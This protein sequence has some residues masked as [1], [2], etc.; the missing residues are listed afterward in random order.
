MNKITTINGVL[1]TPQ[2]DFT[3]HA[4]N[5]T[6]HTTEEERAAW[7]AKAETSELSS[8]VDMDTFN[9]HQ[10][11]NSSHI[12]AKEREHW[13]SSVSTDDSGNMELPGNLTAGK[14]TFTGSVTANQGINL[15]EIP[16]A[17]N[18]AISKK[19]ADTGNICSDV[20]S[21]RY[22][23]CTKYGS[24][25]GSNAK[26]FAPPPELMYVSRGKNGRDEADY[27]DVAFFQFQNFS[28][29]AW[30]V[31][32]NSTYWHS[33]NSISLVVGPTDDI[34]YHSKLWRTSAPLS[35]DGLFPGPLRTDYQ[36]PIP[37]YYW[38]AAVTIVPCQFSVGMSSYS[39]TGFH[40]GNHVLPGFSWNNNGGNQDYLWLILREGY[41]ELWHS[42]NDRTSTSPETIR[43]T[44]V[45]HTPVPESSGVIGI[46]SQGAHR[47][48][49]DCSGYVQ[50]FQAFESIPGWVPEWSTPV[51]DFSVTAN[52]ISI[53]ANG[54]QV[55]LTTN[56]GQ[57][58]G[59]CMKDAD[60]GAS[61]SDPSLYNMEY[62]DAKL[63]EYANN[64]VT[65]PEN[66]TG[67]KRHFELYF[68][69]RTSRNV[70]MISLT[71][72]A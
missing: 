4:E 24:P 54:G 22:S 66:A 17:K 3:G 12:T 64:K 47:P 46:A 13:N 21:A 11:D 31:N 65:V 27:L 14:A 71:Q 50:T 9:A 19:Y 29:R 2:D 39:S 45:G 62:P 35:W 34:F 40:H 36:D 32:I 48:Y 18:S 8:K 1:I 26:N 60:L 7:N 51:T 59:I 61:A 43:W 23:I 30:R 28:S 38:A 55:E 67:G 56:G 70:A 72:S 10:M 16:A 53:S 58:T 20:L 41:L 63:P 33:T 44:P 15:P 25:R 37:N 68:Y 49:R 52:M 69:S 5:K 57:I 42:S 6:L